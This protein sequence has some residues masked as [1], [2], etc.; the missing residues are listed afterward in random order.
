MQIEDLSTIAGKCGAT[1]VERE[2]Q[3]WLELK[4]GTVNYRKITDSIGDRIGSHMC[5]TSGMRS[6]LEQFRDAMHSF[7]GSIARDILP[8]ELPPPLNNYNDPAQ[9]FEDGRY[10]FKE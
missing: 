4:L 9:G 2:F 1:F 7:D 5:V 3:K 10:N 6:L 8:L